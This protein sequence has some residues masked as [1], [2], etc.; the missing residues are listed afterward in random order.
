MTK[1]TWGQGAACLTEDP[2]FVGASLPTRFKDR[3]V[4]A[5]AQV[6]VAPECARWFP[7]HSQAIAVAV[8]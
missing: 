2:T 6:P 5:L 1:P 4:T 3:C 8:W 7:A